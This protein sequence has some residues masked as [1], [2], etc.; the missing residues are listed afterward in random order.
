[1]RFLYGLKFSE[2][3]GSCV[4]LS[5]SRLDAVVPIVVSEEVVINENALEELAFD[6]VTFDVVAID[7]VSFLDHRHPC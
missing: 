2:N 3:N 7:E 1:M 4:L 5:S 6:E